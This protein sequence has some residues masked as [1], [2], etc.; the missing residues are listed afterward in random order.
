MVTCTIYAT[1]P[2]DCEFPFVCPLS[3]PCFGTSPL[4]PISAA[5]WR[6]LGPG[7]ETLILGGL[8]RFLKPKC[9][10]SSSSLRGKRVLVCLPA[11]LPVCLPVRQRC[12]GRVQGRRGRGEGG[13]VGLPFCLFFERSAKHIARGP[14]G[15]PGGRGGCK[16]RGEGRGGRAG[17][18]GSL[19]KPATETTTKLGDQTRGASTGGGAGLGRGHPSMGRGHPSMGIGQKAGSGPPSSEPFER[20][21][22]AR[23]GYINNPVGPTVSLYPRNCCT[24]RSKRKNR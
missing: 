20:I 10:G 1:V 24:V 3:G 8:F 22:R 21:R 7:T 13:R 23:W 4:V 15:P 18:R 16:N 12:R 5:A 6:L 17:G 2:L 9:Y 19:F 14:E 11:C